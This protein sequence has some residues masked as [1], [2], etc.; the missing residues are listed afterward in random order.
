MS[1]SPCLPKEASMWSKKPMPLPMLVSP[2]PSRSISTNTL[3]SWVVRSTCPVLD[4][5]N[6]L[7]GGT[8]SGHLFRGTDRHPQPPVGTSLADQHAAV[9]QTLPN[10]MPIGERAEQHKV[11]I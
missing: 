5:N 3:V 1:N 6:L 9:E 7:Q 8:E 10:G 2:D 4:I 11:C